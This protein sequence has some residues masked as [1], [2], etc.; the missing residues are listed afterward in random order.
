MEVCRSSSSS[1]GLLRLPPPP[2][3]HQAASSLFSSAFEWRPPSVAAQA[4]VG[5][6]VPMPSAASGPPPPRAEL[7]AALAALWSVAPPS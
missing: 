5:P 2:A 1:S 6:A 4:P 7:D 3:H